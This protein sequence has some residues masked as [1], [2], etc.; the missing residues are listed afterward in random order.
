MLKDEFEFINKI[1]PRK[2]TQGSL[3]QGIGDDA[4]IIKG[5]EKF[6]HLVCMDTMVEGVHFTR[7]TMSPYMIGYK[8]LAINISDIAAMG[9]IPT[10]YLVSIAIPNNW[11]QQE[12]EEIY[13]GMGELAAIYSIDLIGGDTVSS[14]EGLVVT[15]TALGKVEKGTKL[16]RS[17]GRSDD[18]VFVIG[19]LGASAA[20]LDLLLKNG[21]EGDF[22]DLEKQLLKAHQLPKPQIEAG[23]MLATSGE[24][25][26]LNDISDGIASEANEIATASNM[27]ITIDYEKLPISNSLKNYPKHKQ[28]EW[29]LYGGED[30]QLIGTVSKQ[31]WN[32]IE[33]LFK[34]MNLPITL[35]GE[36]SHSNGNPSVILTSKGKNTLLLKKGYNHFKKGE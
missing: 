15:V 10:Y 33:T 4:A 21:T 16:L 13:E 31:G 8:A 35:I 19:M 17:N 11:S 25:I 18:Y 3:I 34:Q 32:R 12:I 7:K 5:N 30:Y 22:T 28:K 20:G 9:G 26:S 27:T 24:R 6:D 2:T 1:T 29:I 14:K 23:R 36:T